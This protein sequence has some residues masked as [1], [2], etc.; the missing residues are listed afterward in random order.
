MSFPPLLFVVA[1][2][3]GSGKDEIIRAVGDLGEFHAQIVPKH[4]SRYRQQ[5]DGAE[6]IC[7][8]D[9]DWDLD[10]CD[11]VYENF[12]TR[13]GIKTKHIWDGIYRGVPQLLVV[14][15]VSATMSLQQTFGELVRFIYVHSGMNESEFAEQARSRGYDA[16][17]TSARIERYRSAFDL[18]VRNVERFDHVLIHAAENEDL[19]D[20]IFRL[21]RAY[22][23]GEFRREV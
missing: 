5:D 6:M 13:Y 20:Q 10:A 17:Y 22:D 16:E 3:P 4:A 23:R 18:Y 15:A 21:F 2:T 12:G 19:Y 14:S 11:I 8:D 7:M 1:G 9:P